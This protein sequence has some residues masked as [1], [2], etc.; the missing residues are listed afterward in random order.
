[1]CI[2]DRVST[3]S[4]WVKELQIQFKPN[5]FQVKVQQQSMQ[6]L[7]NQG[8]E[9]EIVAPLLY[10]APT[11]NEPL[12][13]P[14]TLIL[15]FKT[16]IDLHYLSIPLQIYQIFNKCNFPKDYYKAA[17]QKIPQ[18][19]EKQFQ[20][21]QVSPEFLDPNNLIKLMETYNF[22]L[23]NSSK[24]N[25]QQD[26]IFMFS[27]TH[28][29]MEVITQFIIN[30][31][32][33]PNASTQLI[34]ICKSVQM[35]LLQHIFNTVSQILSNNATIASNN[36]TTVIPNVILPPNNNNSNTFSLL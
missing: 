30:P 33:S 23:V 27:Q 17:W 34:V 3:Q 32:N 18:G 22:T 12:S 19:N 6:I 21:Q 20:I 24:N 35:E 26:V 15:G 4:T 8:C 9:K 13:E 14:L 31:K 11:K 1:M 16:N 25:Y 2:R 5:L 29:N 7:I 28:N 36:M 10:D